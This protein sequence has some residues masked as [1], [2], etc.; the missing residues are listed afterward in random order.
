MNKANEIYMHL[1]VCVCVYIHTHTH[2]CHHQLCCS[3]FKASQAISSV[4]KMQKIQGEHTM[5]YYSVTSDTIVY[6]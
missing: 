2:I 5:E 4:V 1:C 6:M 3:A